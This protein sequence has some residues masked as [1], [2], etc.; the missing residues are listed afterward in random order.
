MKM[1]VDFTDFIAAFQYRGRTANFQPEGLRALYNYLRDYEE[2]LGEE[3]EL[4]V[5]ALCCDYTEYASIED[6]A[7]AYRIDTADIDEALEELR[8]R[9]VVIPF[10]LGVILQNF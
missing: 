10:R 1:K 3:L 8:D 2:L 7:D 6:A 4:D 9:T 5:I